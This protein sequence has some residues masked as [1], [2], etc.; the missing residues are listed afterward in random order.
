MKRVEITKVNRKDRL[1]ITFMPLVLGM[2]SGIIVFC[3]IKKTGY[4]IDVED[5]MDMI[6]CIID[7]WGILLG[8]I[9]T[10]AS[11]LMTVG[12]NSYI[13]AL[14]ETNH[15]SNIILS[16]AMS[17]I[18]LFVSLVFVIL[19]FIIKVWSRW[20]FSFFVGANVCIGFSVAICVYFLFS[21][22]L[23]MN[24]RNENEK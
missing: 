5:G 23:A 8:F 22:A 14:V 7:V 6:D 21:I 15:M 4:V 12:E 20:A 17:S 19:L 16:Y 10:A 18:Y 11:V 13:N 3:T 9:I 24:R 1:I 2:I